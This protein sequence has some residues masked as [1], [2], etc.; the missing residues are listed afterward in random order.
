MIFGY[1]VKDTSQGTKWG[2]T[3]N[4]IIVIQASC[5]RVL[6]QVVALKMRDYY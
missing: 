6:N 5:N 1:S 4:I 3:D 2:Q